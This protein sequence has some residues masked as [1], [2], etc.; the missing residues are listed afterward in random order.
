MPNSP[1]KLAG[2]RTEPPVS[3]PSAV[4]Q[5]PPATAAAEP[6]DDP[7][8]TRSGALLFSGVP[9]KAFSPSM[10]S[11]TSSVIVLPISVA[12]ASSSV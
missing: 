12:P 1:Q 4:S 2:T 8:G 5:S 6:E 11:E 3:V 10:P 7:P 9:S